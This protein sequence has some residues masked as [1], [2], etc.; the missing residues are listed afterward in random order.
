ME[1]Y[2]TYKN[3]HDTKM[4][5][6]E[7]TSCNKVMDKTT[8]INN[9]FMTITVFAIII[10]LI[11]FKFNRV[12]K[13]ETSAKEQIVFLEKIFKERK[14]KKLSVYTF[15]TQFTGIKI[16]EE[17]MHEYL[18]HN[19]KKYKEHYNDEIEYLSK[20][21]YIIQKNKDSQIKDVGFIINIIIWSIV[22]AC[23]FNL[24]YQIKA[25]LLVSNSQKEV[26]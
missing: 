18:M 11:E 20:I 10:A 19:D 6:S 3:N 21:K 16:T 9:I 15:P 23:F 14:D 13:I 2:Y 5:K 4:N 26:S 1:K 12:E 24:Y 22:I 8:I 25:L 7:K 17:S